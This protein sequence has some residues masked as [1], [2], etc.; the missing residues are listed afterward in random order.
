MLEQLVAGAKRD[1]WGDFDGDLESSDLQAAADR[2]RKAGLIVD[3]TSGYVGWPNKEAAE[4]GHLTP[5]TLADE[6]LIRKRLRDGF[7]PDVIA[8]EFGGPR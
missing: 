7:V 4:S 3:V 2:L 8:V 5:Q 1:G 6:Q